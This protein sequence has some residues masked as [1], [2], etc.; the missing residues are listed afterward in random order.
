MTGVFLPLK[1]RGG[2]EKLCWFGNVLVS[3]SYCSSS[4]FPVSLGC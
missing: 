3:E 4:Y 1:I 2:G